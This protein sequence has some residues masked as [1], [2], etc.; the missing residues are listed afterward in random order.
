MEI[1][2]FVQTAT[3]Y[4][5]LQKF[6]SNTEIVSLLVLIFKSVSHKKIKMH[7]NDTEIR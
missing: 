6:Y 3:R 5:E 7:R 2:L 4:K 1:K